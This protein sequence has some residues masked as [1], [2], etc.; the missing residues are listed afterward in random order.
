LRFGKEEGTVSSA[1]LFSCLT[2]LRTFDGEWPSLPGSTIVSAS[3]FPS[4][5]PSSSSGRGPD[6][7]GLLSLRDSSG[8]VVLDGLV[9]VEALV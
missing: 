5:V 4:A 3:E 7:L 8:L 6:A 2:I 1:S 9:T